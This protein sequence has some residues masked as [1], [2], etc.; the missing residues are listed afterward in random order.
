MLRVIG[1]RQ[2]KRWCARHSLDVL[3]ASF[4]LETCYYGRGFRTRPGALV[5]SP[6][7][8]T[9]YSYRWSDTLWAMG[10]PSVRV[11]IALSAVSGITREALSLI[12]RLMYLG[13]QEGI[14]VTM[15]DGKEHFLVPQRNINEFEMAI[16]VQLDQNIAG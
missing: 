3:S 5:V 16:R 15:T 14:A 8:I 11:D 2:Y 6:G 13:T 9:H 12:W 7:L 4:Q 10:E 1:E